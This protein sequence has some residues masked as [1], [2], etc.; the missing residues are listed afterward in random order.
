MQAL[1]EQLNQTFAKEQNELAYAQA[2]R[3]KAKPSEKAKD[4]EPKRKAKEHRS[5]ENVDH[6]LDTPDT[7]VK[8]FISNTNCLINLSCQHYCP[9]QHQRSWLEVYIIGGHIQGLLIKLQRKPNMLQF[10]R[11]TI[12]AHLLQQLFRSCCLFSVL[13][14]TGSKT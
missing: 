4:P 8:L 3:K 1:R 12:T 5:K 2:P 11:F 6:E 13:Q 14:M 9:L 7:K 10:V